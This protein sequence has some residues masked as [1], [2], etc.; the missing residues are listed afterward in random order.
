MK[1]YLLLLVS[2]IL[3]MPLMVIHAETTPLAL[4]SEEANSLNI[5]IV[6]DTNIRKAS[7]MNQGVNGYD[8][9]FD[10]V[11][12]W[13]KTQPGIKYALELYRSAQNN[14]Y[15]VDKVVFDEMLSLAPGQSVHKDLSYHM[16]ESLP[17][18]ESYKMQIVLSS[19]KGLT[20]AISNAG[21]I[22]KDS[23][24]G[25][26][27]DPLQCHLQIGDKKY[28]SIQGVDLALEEKL[29]FV[30]ENVVNLGADIDPAAYFVTKKRTSFGEVVSQKEMTQ[31]EIFRAGEKK[32]ISYVIDKV[33][34]AQAYEGSFSLRLDG[35]KDVSNSVIFRYVIQGEAATIQNATTDKDYYVKGDV[36]K[37]AMLTSGKASAFPG[38]RDANAIESMTKADDL[39]LKLNVV[40]T[41]N[42]A[43]SDESVTKFSGFGKN[44][45]VEI[46]ITVDCQNPT[47]LAKIQNQSGTTLDQANFSIKT[48][49][50]V[51]G[52]KPTE[53]TVT[54]IQ[55]AKMLIAIIPFII[56]GIY[57]L[58][59]RFRKSRSGMNLFV[60]L[61][62]FGSSL[63]LQVSF[64]DAAVFTTGSYHCF[65]LMGVNGYCTVTGTYDAE[66]GTSCSSSAASAS[67]HWNACSNITVGANLYINNENVWSDN[68]G[69]G[70]DHATQIDRYS[71]LKT[72]DLGNLLS[73]SH[74]IPFRITFA[75]DWHD[76]NFLEATETIDASK[77]IT[78]GACPPINQ[79]PANPVLA[80]SV[81]GTIN[82]G[83]NFTATTTDPDNDR[84]AYV[85]DW[86]NDGVYDQWVP[87]ITNNAFNYVNSGVTQTAAHSWPAAGTYNVRAKARDINGNYSGWSNTITATIHAPV[88]GACDSTTKA[89]TYDFNANWNEYQ[90]WCS[91][92]SGVKSPAP[93]FP[94]AGSTVSWTC[95]G[96]YTG[97]NKTNCSACHRRDCT[98]EAQANT[99][100]GKS[101]DNGC[102]DTCHGTKD[103]RDLNWREVAPN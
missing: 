19:E 11:N 58:S 23:Q 74:T 51:D 15:L 70:R 44:V 30:C 82:T 16:P 93:G 81:D 4:N 99:C 33:D 49:S 56:V 87:A 6:A 100:I 69:G 71:G 8:V 92:G 9:G 83:Y 94:V 60:G 35:K 50:E 17:G 75:H 102:D 43:C 54:P 12:E 62:I 96:S 22:K 55:I 59:K 85:L 63:L 46:P 72:K 91:A 18:N 1:K 21:I 78:V 64:A 38:A 95:L 27:I 39:V 98:P 24:A 68:E 2:V 13:S 88:A 101:Y 90:W 29:E 73:G 89:R 76:W 3:S 14:Q 80:S 7:V 67:M 31:K 25:I 26:F 28:S 77:V 86:N 47:V 41:D 66:A 10:I 103:C 79:P 52:I 32:N 40:D 34:A 20:L 53:T 36:A 97:A 48:T 5:E 42:Q 45:Q 65:T 37:V 84:I 57:F 61:M